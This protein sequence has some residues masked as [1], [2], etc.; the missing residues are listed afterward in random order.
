MDQLDRMYRRLVHNIRAAFPDLLNQP[1]EVASLHQHLIPYR[2]NRGELGLD[3]AEEYELTVTRLLSGARGLLLGD[4]DMQGALL[5]ELESPNPD[6]SA[7]RAFGTAQ[8]AL[9]QDAVR[10]LDAREAQLAPPN[11][12]L[13]AA[14]READVR[15]AEM[16]GRATV[17][18]TASGTEAPPVR[19]DAPAPVM[20]LPI[21]RPHQSGCRYCGGELPDAREVHFCP[22]C[23]QNLTVKQCPACSTELE[24]DWQYCINCGRQA[25]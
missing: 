8:V 5:T 4:A 13:K 14:P 23:G 18:V 9:S 7:F 3:S 12:P 21:A 22:H 25:E 24:V 2:L 1:F 16:A 15:K 11:A 20:G 19:N 17:E 6:L 10:A